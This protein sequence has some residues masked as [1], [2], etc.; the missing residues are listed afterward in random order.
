[1]AAKQEKK[2]LVNDPR[3]M[4]FVQRYAFDCTRFAIEVCGLEPTWQQREMFDSVSSFGSR[5]SISSGH[6]T[7]KTSGFAII[8]LWHLLC[9]FNSNT[10]ITAP[11]LGTVKD[12]VWKEFADL[13]GKIDAGLHGWIGQY[14]EVAHERVYVKGSKLNW[15]VT[16]K[17]APR[18]S[19]ENM[20]G[21][22]RDFLLWLADE[23]SGIPDKNFGVI[24]GALTDARNRFC[25]A[26]QPT[27]P[28]GFFY[29]THNKLS[30]NNGGTWNN[31]IF[32]SEDSPLVSD[33]FLHNKILEYGGRD[34]VEYQIKVLGE[35]PENSDKYLVGRKMVESRIGLA[36]VIKAGE[37]YGN[38]LMVDVAAG[39]YR[40]K[41]VC[42]H[43]KVT[44]SS[45]YG[46]DARRMDVV[47]IPLFTNTRNIQ[48][49]TGSLFH[50]AASIPNCTVLVDAGGMGIAVCQQ[51]ETLGLPNVVR[52]KWGNPCFKTRYKDRFFNQRA[53]ATVLASKAV[54]EGRMTLPDKYSKELL[55]QASRIPYHFDEKARYVIEKKEDMRKDGIPSPDLWDAIC[56]GFLEDAHYM[57]AESDYL[58]G[59]DTRKT[60][61]RGKASEALAGLE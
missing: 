15:F 17:T 27:R 26:S 25:I 13:K 22:H 21:T 37:M 44:G 5:T 50:L 59:A 29:D 56:F 24:G 40:D 30:I 52:V 46:E 2:F 57:I 32:N 61:A 20:A 23:A 3:F 28:S 39:E 38:L 42:V 35:F 4:G 6:G 33:E 43:A 53:Q 45:D 60:E 9:Y 16:A 51:L 34:S 12:G 8:A 7:G 1:M 10:F 19:P 41:S 58:A 48:D 36:G 14:F 11:K 54:K 49:F 31:L 47:D 18:G 55:D